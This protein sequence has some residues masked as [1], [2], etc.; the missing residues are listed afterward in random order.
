VLLKV[1]EAGPFV[2]VGD[3]R[4]RRAGK[5]LRVERDQV[6]D[7]IANVDRLRFAR[8]QL[9]VFTPRDLLEVRLLAE[10][11][12]ERLKFLSKIREGLVAYL[13][14]GIARLH[15]V[16]DRLSIEASDD[17]DSNIARGL[18]LADFSDSVRDHAISVAAIEQAVNRWVPH[19]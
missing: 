8:L 19:H 16:A 5:A 11:A 17:L 10:D 15:N 18:V 7:N 12:L 3:E 14:R 9:L 2:L 13:V 1:A 6:G 4:L